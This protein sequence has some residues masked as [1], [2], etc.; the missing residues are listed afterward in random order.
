MS[1]KLFRNYSESLVDNVQ[2]FAISSQVMETVKYR[3]TWE[4]E[5]TK[6]IY[7]TLDDVYLGEGT[8]YLLTHLLT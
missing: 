1:W 7:N 5:D 8:T 4:T 2:Q 3:M 6:C